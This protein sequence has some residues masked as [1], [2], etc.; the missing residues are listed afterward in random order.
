MGITNFLNCL[1]HAF[2][3]AQFIPV[4]EPVLGGNEKKYVN[5]CLDT[6]WISS[7]GKYVTDFES[8]FSA[9]CERK[10]GTSVANGTV[11]LQLALIALDIKAGDEVMFI[12][13]NGVVYLLP[14]PRSFAKALKGIAKANLKYPNGYLRKEKASW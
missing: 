3:M 6:G 12:T 8:K 9:F 4:Y 7:L 10:N 11:A 13:R 1:S 2:L 5:D 14:K